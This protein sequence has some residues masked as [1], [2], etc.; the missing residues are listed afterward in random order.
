MK[1]KKIALL[2]S[3]GVDSSYCA[4]LLKEQGYEVLGMYLKLHTKE[5]KHN[6]FI[7]NCENVSRHLN[8]DFIVVDA[9]DEF[10]ESVYDY[11]IDSYK[12]GITPNPCAV[13][14]PLMKFGLA[15]DKAKSLGCEFIATGHYARI[16]KLNG[17]NRIKCALD[18]SKDQSYFLYALSQD[19]LDRLV[20]PLG[21]MKKVDIKPKAL[22]EMP[23]LGSLETYK[24][25]QEICFVDKSYID[26]LQ[27]HV[28]V[29]KEG[30]VLDI[31]GKVVGKH[32]GYMQYTIGKRKGFSVKGAL[33]P[34]FVLDINPKTNQIIVGEKKDLETFEVKAINK[35]LPENF[36]NGIYNVKVRYRSSL[37]PAKV[38]LNEDNTIV[39]N[40]EEPVF[41][42]AK[43]QALVIYN[44]DI[45]V[46]GGVI[47]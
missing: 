29:D 40:L 35:S 15:L 12:E 6:V 22:K 21:D 36:T 13:C 20:F 37:S 28:E 16:E 39:A 19:A 41:G 42:V 47:V 27:K 7:K 11:F 2:M 10:K 30:E 26:L 31:N 24:E 45:V 1:S 46:G 4:Y 17:V 32:K 3:G 9:K 44:D 8:I 14:N 38:T 23:F 33:T 25:S 34:H 18:T 43:G 5:E